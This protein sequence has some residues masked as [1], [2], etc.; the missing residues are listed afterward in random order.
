MVEIGMG[1]MSQALRD[2]MFTM[3]LKM[4]FIPIHVSLGQAC[5]LF[6]HIG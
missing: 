4:N 2:L 5:Q 3:T 1:Y 6:C